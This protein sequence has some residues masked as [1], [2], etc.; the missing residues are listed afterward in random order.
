MGNPESPSWTSKKGW[1]RG[2]D[3]KRE[4]DQRNR[5]ID[6]Q[7]RESDLEVSQTSFYEGLSQQGNGTIHES[8]PLTPAGLLDLRT[9]V[10]PE[11]ASLLELISA[12][13]GTVRTITDSPGY[14][15]DDIREVAL[16]LSKRYPSIRFEFNEN[17][18]EFSYTATT[19]ERKA[20]SNP[21]ARE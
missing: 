5:E 18:K 20:K 13:R 9:W 14:K 8:F 4:V 7:N 2:D 16:G 12:I 1:E 3:A 6:Q 11:N 17:V 15:P 19:S 10:P 21:W